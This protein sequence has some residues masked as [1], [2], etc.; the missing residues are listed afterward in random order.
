MAHVAGEIVI[1]RPVGEVFD[2]VA[3]E[4]NEP[5]Y[6]P[7]LRQVELISQGPI[8]VGARFTAESVTRGRA[9]PMVIELTAF[10]RPRRLASVTRM[11]SME[12]R[13]GLTFDAVA[14]G[15]RLRWSWELEPRGALK[16]LGPLIGFIGRRQEA[17][18]W[19][20]LK[21]YLEARAA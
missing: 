5:L 7:R 10:E 12:I 14:G 21:Q 1:G 2:C 17:A 9:V 8:G 3:D 6:N 15:T 4:R 20:G 19:S 11:S 18:C 13:G 16:L